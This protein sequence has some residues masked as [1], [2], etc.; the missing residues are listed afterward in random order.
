[1]L[2]KL[3][4]PISGI[5]KKYLPL[6]SVYFA[7]NFLIFSQ[8]AETFWIKNELHLTSGE[9]ISIS[10]WTGLPWSM[11]ILLA[12]LVDSVKISGSQ[13]KSYIF[14]ASVFM[15]IGNIVNI[16]IANKFEPVM[17]IASIYHLFIISGFFITL[18]VIFQDL[19][20]DTLCYDVVDKNQSEEAIKQEIGEVQTIVKVVEVF[21]TML[22]VSISGM[23]ATKFSYAMISYVIPLVTFFSILGSL[24][25]KKEPEVSKQNINITMLGFGGLYLLII[26]FFAFVDSLYAQE[27]IFV[28]GTLIVSAALY[29]LCSHLTSKQKREIF[30]VILVLFTC[31]AVPTYGPG[32]DWWQI[33]VLHFTPEFYSTL[34]QTATVLSF[35]GIW[36]FSKKI[37]NN[38]AGMMLLILNSIHVAL[39]LPLIA[40]AFGFHEWTMQNFG[41][42]AQ[43]IA[44][45]DNVAEG[46]FLRLGFLIVCNIAALHAPKENTANWFAL[47]MSLMSLAYV[48]GGRIFKKILSNIYVIERGFYDNVADLMIV[49]TA[50]NFLMPTIVILIF[51]NPFKRKA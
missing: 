33:D 35:I 45:I 43:T 25:I 16:A 13:R 31:R 9:I 30:C 36:F 49:T 23:I 46:P 5:K 4:S 20:A 41:F 21:A 48:S 1:M 37:I 24:I 19:V 39:Q 3:L 22:A 11:K 28:A 10:I 51:M 42:G 15:L 34:Y 29:K 8:I 26:G 12:Q 32:V 17:E 40:M 2:S 6:L 50:I 27:I 7:N 44:L 14:I 47:V 38:H 18:G